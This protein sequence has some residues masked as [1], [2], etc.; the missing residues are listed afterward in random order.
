MSPAPTYSLVL[1]KNYCRKNSDIYQTNSN[2]WRTIYSL[3][4]FIHIPVNIIIGVLQY[5]PFH[6]YINLNSPCPCQTNYSQ[7]T[8]PTAATRLNFQ[9]HQS[10]Y[11]KFSFINPSRNPY[12][13]MLY[14]SGVQPNI[15]IRTKSK[16]PNLNTFIKLQ[17]LHSNSK[18][19]S[20]NFL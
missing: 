17:K 12:G 18:M 4:P 14:N 15:Q 10:K 7:Q 13:P 6:I 5:F 16:R 2:K 19:I 9:T 20:Y 1:C 11:W 8:I 3:M